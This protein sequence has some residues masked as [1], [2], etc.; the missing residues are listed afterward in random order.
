MVQDIRKK[1]TSRRNFLKGGALAGAA[2]LLQPVA[3]FANF[4]P[5]AAV[6]TQTR[7]MMGTFVTITAVHESKT[8]AEN[9]LG[10]AFETVALLE[11]ELSRHTSSPLT[12]LNATGKLLSAPSSLVHVVQRAQRVHSL[13]NGAFDMT[14]A[15]L[16]DV[17]RK[18]QNPQGRMQLDAADVRAAR[19]LMQAQEVYVSQD[20]VR[21]G[22]SGMALT[23]DGIAKGYIADR[24]SEELVKAGV[25]HHLVNAGGD[26]RCNGHKAAQTPWNVAVEHPARNGEV[27]GTLPVHG[28]IATSGNYEM[29]YDA[30]KKHHHLIDPKLAQSTQYSASVTVTA[31]TALEAD[32]MATALSA[33]PA[34]AA[35]ELINSLPGRECLLVFGSQV[36]TSR[37][38]G[39]A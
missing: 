4:A 20:H 25:E 21:L 11:A 29:Y 37:G 12:H 27:L 6:H 16:L 17:Y 18:A 35:V 33:I 34:P 31:P 19:E 36:L 5:K 2:L 13:T 1:T 9:A 22:R 32:A 26:I 14:V 23:L 28:A 8:L 38:W 10:H 3:S 30:A 24:M 39:K 15:P 7:L